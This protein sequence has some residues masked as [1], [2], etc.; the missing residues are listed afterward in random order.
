M[1]EAKET[2]VG[3]LGATKQSLRGITNASSTYTSEYKLPVASEDT[4]GGVMVGENL[5]IEDDGTLN[6]I[7]P[8]KVSELENDSG[9]LTEVPSEYITDIEL[10]QKGYLTEV[11][12][13]YK[14]KEENDKLYQPIGDYALKGDIPEVPT[15]VSELENDVGFISEIP[16]EY[17][18]EEELNAKN[19]ITEHQDI[20]HLATKDELHS[21]NNKEILDSIS[22]ENLDTWNNGSRNVALSPIEPTNGE[23]I[24]FQK[25]FN[26]VP[27]L[28][29]ITTVIRTDPE[30]PVD[31]SQYYWVTRVGTTD[32]SITVSGTPSQY[33][34]TILFK[35]KLFKKGTYTLSYTAKNNLEDYTGNVDD[36]NRVQFG[37][38]LGW[39]LYEL[40]VGITGNGT[41]TL[42][43]DTYMSLYIANSSKMTQSCTYWIQIEEGSVANPYSLPNIPDKLYVKDGGSEFREFLPN[44]NVDIDLSSYATKE[45]LTS[46]VDKVS[47]KSLIAASEITRLESVTNYDDTA[48]KNTLNRKSNTSDLHNHSN[49]SVLDS[50]TQ[51]N[52]NAWNSGTGGSGYEPN[53][54]TIV[55]RGEQVLT[56]EQYNKVN[57]NDVLS[58]IGDKLT[59][60]DGGIKI[61]AGVKKIKLS[62]Y[63]TIVTTDGYGICHLRLMKNEYSNDNSICW[64]IGS[65]Y[66]SWGQVT[67]TYPSSIVEVNEGDIMCMYIYTVP[68]GKIGANNNVPTSNITAEVIE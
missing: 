56:K 54:M 40:G 50:I 68:N 46:K 67:L 64:L 55:I 51:A 49:K 66:N 2:V 3:S 21:H 38:M 30:T 61:G 22:Q 47:G 25:N 62:G 36:L 31:S 44:G 16:E 18:T 48:I 24:W 11:P 4:L 5:N 28:E 42:E 53:I 39:D 26:L 45:D 19:Y 23:E 52:I 10:A 43:R 57:F 7:V 32:N 1:I 58:S 65:T 35:D 33:F 17:I 20:S 59:L 29:T 34:Y 13:E 14:T 9:Y 41:I 12:S 27:K 63:S 8:K 6:A 60:V 37:N 15:K